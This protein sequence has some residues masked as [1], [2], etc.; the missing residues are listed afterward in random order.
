MCCVPCSI[1]R[2]ATLLPVSVEMYSLFADLGAWCLEGGAGA[3]ILVEAG[4]VRGV[5][6]VKGSNKGVSGG[7]KGFGFYFDLAEQSFH[8]PNMYGV[9]EME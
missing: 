7:S 6:G 9:I 3:D 2:R 1:A 4:G 8:M 5:F